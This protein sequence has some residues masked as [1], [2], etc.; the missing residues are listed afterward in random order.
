MII[1]HMVEKRI[2]DKLFCCLYCC[3]AIYEQGYMKQ[4]PFIKISANFL[5]ETSS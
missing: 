1:N 2:Y 4:F 5:Q 3:V